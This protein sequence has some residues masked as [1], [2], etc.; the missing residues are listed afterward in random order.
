MILAARAFTH[1]R[2]GEPRILPT[3]NQACFR[4]IVYDLQIAQAGSQAG[5][6]EPAEFTYGRFNESKYTKPSK[7]TDGQSFFF[8]T[9][10]RP[11]GG[12]AGGG[13]LPSR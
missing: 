11:A 8:S 9:P 1:L 7:G 4:G 3:A 13:A 2:E 6:V 12:W 10:P 5:F